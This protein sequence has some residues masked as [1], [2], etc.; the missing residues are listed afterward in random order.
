MSFVNIDC[1]MDEGRAQEREFENI[2]CTLKPRSHMELRG[3]RLRCSRSNNGTR[4]DCAENSSVL[5]A[6]L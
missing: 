3:V 6:G 4:F 5:R 2:R 1:I